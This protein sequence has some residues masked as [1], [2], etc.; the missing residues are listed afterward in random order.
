MNTM[1]EW[2]RLLTAVA[3]L[4][5]G[6]AC[7]GTDHMRDEFARYGLARWRMLIG[8]LE[9]CGGLGLALSSLVPALLL[10]SA[11]G[12]GFLMLVGIITRIHIRDSFTQML[13]ALVLL[14]MNTFLISRVLATQ[15]TS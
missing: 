2:T 10:P 13:P 11:S 9:I 12:L 6:I 7:L 1:F 5:F 3:F 8:G 4:G 15:R 14:L